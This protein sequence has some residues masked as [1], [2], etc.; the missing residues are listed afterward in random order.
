MRTL[1][2][3]ALGIYRPSFFSIHLN[4]DEEL[5]DLKKLSP[6]VLSTLIHELVHFIQDITTTYGLMNIVHTVQMQKA[7][8]N[9]IFKSDLKVFERPIKI[10]DYETT[11]INVELLALYVGSSSL[12]CREFRSIESIELEKNDCIPGYEEVCSVKINVRKGSIPCS[13]N[14]GAECILEG[15]A[16]LVEQQFLNEV[17][18]PQF[19]YFIVEN[20]AEFIYPEFARSKIALIFLCDIALNSFHP[21][22]I[23]Y[24]LLLDMK[25][26]SFIPNSQGELFNFCQKYSFQSENQT[27][28]FFS[29][30]LE[31]SG[32]AEKEIKELFTIPLYKKIQTWL[33]NFITEARKMRNVDFCFWDKVF[34]IRNNRSEIECF[35]DLFRSIG[36]PIFSNNQQHYCICNDP[37][38]QKLLLVFPAINEVQEVLF[39]KNCCGLKEYCAK[40]LPNCF[41][42]ND[43]FN[44]P[45]VKS[46]QAQL[47]PFGQVWRMWGLSEFTPES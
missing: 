20:L 40:H 6:K 34:D 23:F 25:K 7:I 33:T 14:F 2:N 29:L 27:S 22:L 39:G 42:E 24:N 21:G 46:N 15:M 1:H 17:D 9:T 13:F 12:I 47:C 4:T 26:Q 36:F 31:C 44:A 11:E 45:W 37:E 19:P 32:Y 10:S 18:H 41:N 38:I 3:D 43:C 30:F 28:G 16:H 5:Q 8:N 35:L